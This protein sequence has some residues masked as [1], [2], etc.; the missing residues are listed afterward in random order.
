M[1]TLKSKVTVKILTYYFLN[2]DLRHYIN[3]L[4]RILKLD[5]KNLLRKLN[6]L[7]KEG[8][9]KSEFVGKQRYFSLNKKS[10]V[11]N[12]YKDLMAQTAGLEEQIRKLIRNVPGTEQAYIYGSY[13]KNTMSTGSDIDILIVGNHSTLKMQ[14]ALNKIQRGMG[15]EINAVNISM[16]ELNLKKKKKDPFIHNIFSGKHIKLL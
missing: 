7:E 14:K 4:A 10:K 1:I 8:I 6:E 9:L 3:E 11:T 2:P 13:A 16:R 12:I 15:R 5:P